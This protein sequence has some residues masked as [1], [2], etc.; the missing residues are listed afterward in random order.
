MSQPVR[1]LLF[2]AIAVAS[3][4]LA[5][6]MHVANTPKKLAEF[7]D[8]GTEFYESFDDPNAAT[9]L[10]VA[11]YDSASGKTNIFKVEYRDGVW[12]IPSHLDYPADGK[13]R[14][15][16]TAASMLHVKRQAL[17]ERSKAAH[18]RYKV[19]DPLDETVQ[20]TEGRGDRIT[21]YTG[22]ETVVDL[23]VG[24]KLDEGKDI[25][26]VRQPG[27][28]QVY[29]ADLG[30]FEISTKFA[31]WIQADLLELD[32]NKLSKIIID[33]YHIDEAKGE[34]VQEERFQLEK[35]AD[36]Q[37]SLSD[38]APETEKVKTSEIN[39]TVNALDDL[40]IVGIR[41]KPES[42]SALLKGEGGRPSLQGTLDMQEKGFF[43]QPSGQIYANQGN[44]VI[45]MNDGV[46]YLVN[47]GEE[48]SGTDVD[49]EVGKGT[50]EEAPKEDAVPKDEADAKLDGETP[51]ADAKPDDKQVN[52]RYLLI[53]ALFDEQ[54]MPPVPTPPVKPEPPAEGD[55]APAA[56]TPADAADKPQDAATDATDKPAD[57]AAE[58]PAEKKEDP[59]AAYDKALKEYE[60]A[61]EVY[62]QQIK[63]RDEDIKKAKEQV[64]NL[65]HRFADWYYVI[66]DEVY[67]KLRLKRETIVEPAEPKKD[68]A[69]PLDSLLQGAPMPPAVTTDPMP[70]AKPAGQPKPEGDTKPAEDKKPEGDAKPEEE[71]KPEGEAKPEGDAKPEAEKPAEA[72][73]NPNS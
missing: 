1:T 54:F 48:F 32:R 40:K 39:S 18:K 26:Y 5:W 31:D 60:L 29:T 58:T 28:D 17:V 22:D 46:V 72:E 12:R 70:E 4:G 16:K 20:G 24:N 71:K 41:R 73:V 45:G 69:N 14:L 37:W 43:I 59:K 3:L 10:Q 8:V 25:Y 21:L 13:D 23:I 15:A 38:L 47:F 61:K 9:G 57:A 51:D 55:A 6:G 19:L 64:E 30:K 67:Q 34:L 36:S 52:G 7:S 62:E 63:F 11:S 56:D 44:A 35:G 53:A 27:K 66:S 68:E 33:N 42:M 65:N 2:A 50:G 49:L